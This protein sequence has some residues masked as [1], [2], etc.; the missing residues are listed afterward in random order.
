MSDEE[1]TNE[2]NSMGNQSHKAWH[3]QIMFRLNEVEWF[4]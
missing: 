3:F 4:W 1:N 2:M